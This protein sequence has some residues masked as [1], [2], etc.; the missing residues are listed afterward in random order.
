M[1]GNEIVGVAVEEDMFA[2]YQSIPL[3]RTQEKRKI[4]Q[5]M[6]KYKKYFQEMMDQN[7]ELFKEFLPIHDGYKTDRKKWSK[8]FHEKGGQVVEVIRD[9]ER[10]L[11]SGMERGNNAVYSS[12][13]AEKFWGEVKELYSHIEL[14][15]V[16]SSLD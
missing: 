3:Y 6:T 7:A 10:R 5:S 2:I 11:C 14:V 12:K 4:N 16:K 15:G 13:L 1:K 9:W 8:Q